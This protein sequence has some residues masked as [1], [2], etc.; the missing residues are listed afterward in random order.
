MK[1]NYTEKLL[2]AANPVYSMG[3]CD[4]HS[5]IPAGKRG[6]GLA[7]FIATEVR[8]VTMHCPH[9][10]DEAQSEAVRAI[11][12]A[13]QQLLDV[14]EALK[15]YTPSSSTTPEAPA[16]PPIK[17]G[18]DFK[19]TTPVKFDST[20]KEIIAGEGSYHGCDYSV[21]SYYLV[22]DKHTG[23]LYLA[24]DD[25]LGA[26]RIVLHQTA[27]EIA[28][29]LGMSK[30]LFEFYQHRFAVLRLAKNEF[31][32]SYIAL[33]TY[34]TPEV[35]QYPS[36]RLPDLVG[37]IHVENFFL[38]GAASAKPQLKVE[39]GTPGIKPPAWF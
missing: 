16:N 1:T 17:I 23:Q 18:S 15:N 2:L 11:E 37:P 19:F 8:E 14:A 38:A 5:N 27:A 34:L 30:E 31:S 4:L 10:L 22:A 25:T 29:S 9:D 12:S 26:D 33:A 13:A 24:S 3:E 20:M 6:D 21:Q 28:T 35:S 7:D 39:D 36:N 32:T